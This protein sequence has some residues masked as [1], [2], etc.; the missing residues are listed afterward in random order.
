MNILDIIILL[1]VIWFAFKGLKAGFVGGIFSILA[2]IIGGWATVHLTDFTSSFFGLDGEIKG[3]LASGI[4]FLVVVVLV[5]LVGKVCKSIVRIV[6]PEFVDKL[7]GL[8]LG[9]GKVLLFVGIL[10]Y[11]TTNIDANEKILTPERKQASFFY[12]PSLKFAEF[13]L[14]QFEKIKELKEAE[15]KKNN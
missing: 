8:V 6:L 11:L 9:G 15:S 13:L 1:A 3:L 12:T 7:L 14:P 2:L 10:F 5:F 4:T